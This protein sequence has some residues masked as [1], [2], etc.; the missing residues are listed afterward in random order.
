MRNVFLLT[1]LL[2]AML[3]PA[4]GAGE[5][6]N[7]RAPGF[8]LPDS[9]LKQYDVQDFR[10]KIVLID[11]MMTNCPHCQAFSKI[12]E[13]IKARFGDNVMI[14]EVVNYASDNAS[15]VAEYIKT[16]HV[17]VPVLFD[18]GQMA[19]SYL[20]LTSS[21]RSID[22]PHVFLIDRRGIIRND[23]ANTEANKAIFEGAALTFEI[24][25]MLA[26]KEK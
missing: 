19:A 2:A 7:R 4:Y 13:Q 23:Y 5:L 16:S 6:S 11:F 15:T 1:L 24:E 18:C 22:L 25:R 26:S 3:A 21:R 20:K 14:L 8:S 17:S 9:T 12:L 10:G